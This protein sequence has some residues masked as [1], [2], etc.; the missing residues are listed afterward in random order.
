VPTRAEDEAVTVPMAFEALERAE[1][2][3]LHELRAVPH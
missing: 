2:A 3:L 1:D